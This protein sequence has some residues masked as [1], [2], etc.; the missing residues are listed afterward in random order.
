M[1]VSVLLRSLV[2]FVLLCLFLPGSYSLASD[3]NRPWGNNHRALV[4]DAYELNPIDWNT[5]SKNKRIVGFINKA[6]DGM[7]PQYN[8]RK[9][10]MEQTRKLCRTEF[11]KY[12]ITRE[13]FLARKLIARQKGIKW[14]AYHLGRPGNPVDQANHFIKFAQPGPDDLIALDIEDNDP[15]KWMSLKDAEIFAKHIKRRI[16]RYP[17]LYLNGNTAKFIARNADDYP[18]LSRLGLWYA[19]YKPNI[20]GVF[21][22][23][24]WKSYSIWQFAYSGNCNK[25][26]C[27]YRVKGTKHNIDVNVTKYSVS[28]LKKAW[29][30]AMIE[31]PDLVVPIDTP[32][33]VASATATEDDQQGEIDF[34]TTGSIVI[35]DKL[36]PVHDQANW[37]NANFNGRYN[38]SIN[39]DQNDVALCDYSHRPVPDEPDEM[40]TARW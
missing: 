33:A 20:K 22:L 37:R 35:Q 26:R 9:G 14:G 19:R 30:L 10:E 5:L 23:G 3:Y 25:R 32:L 16:G 12:A 15:E 7:P 27:P 8:C 24:N 34:M 13:L 29:P 31:L 11:R 17:L 2:P 28:G 36:I 18:V 6:S 21:P 40:K 4:L 38:Q 1:V 39:C